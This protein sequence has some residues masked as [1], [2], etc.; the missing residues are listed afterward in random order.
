MTTTHEDYGWKDAQPTCAHEYLLPAVQKCI[1]AIWHN[2][3]ARILDIGCGNGYVAAQLAALGHCVIAVDASA[4]GIEIARTAYPAVSFAVGSVY[5]D[6]LSDIVGDGVDCIVSL[7]VV[8][9]LF[10][11]AKLFAQSYR[12]LK[13]GGY[14]ILSTPYHGYLKNLAISLVHGWDRHF[15]VEWDGGHIKFFSNRTLARMACNAGFN[16]PR[17]QGVG[18]LPGLWKSIVMVAQK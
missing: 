5:D 12:L 7:E 15:H 18:R 3:R 11:P 9:H 16:K 13:P 8:E 17:F 1:E 14:L 6:K 10:Y 4:D 2:G